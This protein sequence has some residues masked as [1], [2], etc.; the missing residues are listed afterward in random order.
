M[1]A[2]SVSDNAILE[3]EMREDALRMFDEYLCARELNQCSEEMADSETISDIEALKNKAQRFYETYLANSKKKVILFFFK[4]PIYGQ[5]GINTYMKSLLDLIP[6]AYYDII[7][8]YLDSTDINFFLSSS[9]AIYHFPRFINTK[10]PFYQEKLSKVIFYTIASKLGINKTLIC[11]F[12]LYGYSRLVKLL[13]SKLN[14][15]LIFTVHYTSWGL[16]LRGQISMIQKLKE[17]HKSQL[18]ERDSKILEL[19]SEEEQNFSNC[20]YVIAPSKFTINHLKL[21]YNIQDSKIIYVPHSIEQFRGLST[22]S[23]NVIRKEYG[24]GEDHY[25][26]LYVGRIDENKGLEN[27]ISA[28]VRLYKQSVM[29]RLIVAGDGDFQSILKIIPS[30]ARCGIIFVG[31]AENNV[32]C[33]LMKMADV[34]VVPSY[35]E[36]F[37]YTAAEMLM[38]GMPVVC[39]NTSGLQQFKQ[40]Y[41]NINYFEH[42]AYNNDL[43][44]CLTEVLNKGQKGNSE[45]ILKVTK[46]DMNLNF[47]K[48]MQDLY[49]IPK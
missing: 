3:Y 17:Q 44:K 43:F 49:E 42:D 13:K 37:G 38:T 28:F 30:F 12:N 1:D 8:C 24:L 20:D 22:K 11:H 16:N 46:E 21:V 18:K 39:A 9:Y 6:S 45:Q 40:W 32:L 5:Y 14:A 41:H 33:E 27:L 15:K 2:I 26:F 7:V 36:E 34:G 29:C 31:F 48:C 25:I 10:I 47:K 19:T 23:R 35:Y 4:S